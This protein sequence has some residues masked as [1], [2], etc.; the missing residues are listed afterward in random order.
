MNNEL[1]DC[2]I[3]SNSIITNLNDQ[4]G[5]RDDIVYSTMINHHIVDSEGK[6]TT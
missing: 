5:R 4:L 1:N 6:G 3:E 2:K